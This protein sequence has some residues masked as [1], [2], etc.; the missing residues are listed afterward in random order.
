MMVAGLL[1]DFDS[2]R[3]TARQIENGVTDQSVVQDHVGF[4]QCTQCAQ[5]QQAR[6]AGTGAD[7]RYAAAPA[8]L[9]L[10]QGAIEFLLRL[11][12]SIP[13]QQ[14]ENFAFDHPRVEGP[15]SRQI[16]DPRT[17]A[18][19]R[20]LE[21][22]GQRTQGRVEQ[23]FEALAHP[24]RQHRG[25]ASGRNRNLQRRAIDHGRDMERRQLRI[26]DDID[27]D[28]ASVRGVGHAAIDRFFIGCRD[29]QPRAF[30]PALVEFADDVPNRAAL[31]PSR[32]LG[33]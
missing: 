24:A 29:S 14:L 3:I 18:L 17:D 25:S 31:E 2:L 9:F 4:I 1:A 6:I 22:I 16:A 13:S 10:K 20:T 28:P 23:G 15:P 19:A 11:P 5:R 33:I 26:I 30:Q 21:Q 27:E 8:R 12:C 7:Q 32:Q